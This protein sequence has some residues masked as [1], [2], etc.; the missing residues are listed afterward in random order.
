MHINNTGFIHGRFQIFH[1][2]HLVYA[3]AAKELCETLIIGI[4]SP[5]PSVSPEEKIDPHRSQESSNPCTFYERL[6][7]IKGT[8]I[9]NGLTI[10]EFNIVPMPIGCPELIKYYVPDYAISYFTIYD[11]WGYEKLKR[12]TSLGYKTHVLWDNRPKGISGI[13]IRKAIVSEQEWEHLVPPFV[14]NYI[15]THKIN[16]RIRLQG[17]K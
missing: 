12:I 6:E 14:Y 10:N 1:N 16:E 8:L 5:D 13:Q 15:I 17:K 11:N 3:L 9:D 4:T 2:D 7:M